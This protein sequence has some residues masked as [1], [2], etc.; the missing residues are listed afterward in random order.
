MATFCTNLKIRGAGTGSI[1]YPFFCQLTRHP[2][3]C[4]RS[5]HRVQV[6]KMSDKFMKKFGKKGVGQE[7]SSIQHL[8]QFL[9]IV[10]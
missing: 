4:D 10:G 9:I 7:S 2:M 5:N 6:F 1:M 8:Q 3:V